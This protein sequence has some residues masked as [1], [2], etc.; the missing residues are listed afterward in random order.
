[1]LQYLFGLHILGI[2]HQSAG[3]TIQA[4]HHMR[5]TVLA[6]LL[7][8]VVQD[9]LDVQ[10]GMACSHGEDAYGFLHHNEPAILVD[11][12]HITATEG[13][14]VALGLADSHLHPRFQREIKLCHRLAIDLDALPLQRGLDLR[15]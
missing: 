11:N 10:R 12:L 13:L 8:I 2:D 4:M 6:R 15:A 7:E 14:L 5:C 1:M 9:T 3:V